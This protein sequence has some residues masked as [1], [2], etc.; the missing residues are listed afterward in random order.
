MAGVN[1]VEYVDATGA[2]RF[3]KW[4][5]DLNAEA[6]AKVTTALYRLGMVILL[7]GSSKKRQQQA[8]QTAWQAWAEYKMRKATRR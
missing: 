7:G 8:I 2:S 5:E 4:F 6:A 3:A 1:V